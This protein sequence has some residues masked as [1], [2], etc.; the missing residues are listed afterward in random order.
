MSRGRLEMKRKGREPAAKP[1]TYQLTEEER[2]A[3][4]NVQ[5]RLDKTPRLKV[6]PKG[7]E[8]AKLMPD[9]PDEMFGYM[10][11]MGALGTADRD[12][13]DGLLR[14]CPERSCWIAEFSE[15]E[16]DRGEAQEGE[17]LAVEVL[18]IFGEPAAAIEPCD[19]AL[20]DPALGQDRKSFDVIGAFDDFGF[21]AWQHSSQ[22]VVEGGTLIG[23]VGKELGQ[24]RM[25]SEHRG[26]QQDAA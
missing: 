25:Q 5:A 7:S 17:S 2:V 22:G 9:H 16:A 10:L 3:L 11:L 4:R 14:V 6:V 18:P 23:G 15:H 26:E 21:D 8:P 12:F 24:E 19:G 13:T 1:A 20:D